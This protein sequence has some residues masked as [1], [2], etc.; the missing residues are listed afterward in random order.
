L[1][2]SREGRKA[3]HA[4][5]LN[6]DFKLFLTDLENMK[7]SAFEDAVYTDQPEIARGMARAYDTLS[8]T[9]KEA[10]DNG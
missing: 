7:T 3:V 1:K 6:A 8:K 2:L 10:I 9:L 4:L 5:R